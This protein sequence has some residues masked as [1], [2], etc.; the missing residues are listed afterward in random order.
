MHSV[1]TEQRDGVSILNLGGRIDASNSGQVHER[2]MDEIEE[3]RNAIVIDFSEVSYISSAGLRIL[4]HASKTLMRNSGAF[5]ICS[6]NKNIE[7]IF[8]ISGLTGLFDIRSDVQASI[9][10]INQ[11]LS[12]RKESSDA[13]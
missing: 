1:Y 2:I 10:A 4:V 9:D 11:K 7:K 6:V 13:P 12:P 8:Q 5:S 3:G